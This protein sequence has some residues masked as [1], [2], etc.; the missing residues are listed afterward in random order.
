MILPFIECPCLCLHY[1]HKPIP[2]P[3]FALPLPTASPSIPCSISSSHKHSRR[4]PQ[5]KAQTGKGEL[6][7]DHTITDFSAYEAVVD[8]THRYREIFY[9]AE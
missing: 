4:P 7:T 8:A 5:R 3:L 1:L 9:D 2:S 6:Q